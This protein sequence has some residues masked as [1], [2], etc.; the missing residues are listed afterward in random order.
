M[1]DCMVQCIPKNTS[2]TN[3]KARS[4]GVKF[5]FSELIEENFG[6]KITEL[7]KED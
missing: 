2:A 4:I 7:K 1:I 3:K 6:G 5:D